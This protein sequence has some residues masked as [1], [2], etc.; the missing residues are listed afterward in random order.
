MRPVKY[1]AHL[2]HKR[3]LY[4]VINNRALFL[5]DDTDIKDYLWQ[6]VH[7]E[8]HCNYRY[9]MLDGEYEKAVIIIEPHLEK[10]ADHEIERRSKT[11]TQQPS[12]GTRSLAA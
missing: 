12:S 1:Q 3:Y 7:N 5:L 10:L 8:W 4:S 11:K 9:K 6:C 2:I